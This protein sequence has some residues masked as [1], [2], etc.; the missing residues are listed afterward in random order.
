[1]PKTLKTAFLVV[2]LLAGIG[3][4]GAGV[5]HRFQENPG[6]SLFAGLVAVLL[7]AMGVLARP[8]LRVLWRLVKR[9]K[10]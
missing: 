8:V 4:F 9:M 7:I 5:W 3:V 2:Y 10:K 1:M 6:L